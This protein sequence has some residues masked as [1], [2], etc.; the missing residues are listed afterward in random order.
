MRW[1]PL[2]AG[3][4][5][6]RNGV[7]SSPSIVPGNGQD[8]QFEVA[9][10][11]PASPDRARIH[12]VHHVRWSGRSPCQGRYLYQGSRV[13]ALQRYP[14]RQQI[15]PRLPGTVAGRVREPGPDLR[16][17]HRDNA[18]RCV[19]GSDQDRLRCLET[20][21]QPSMRPVVGLHPF[22]PDRR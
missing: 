21:R 12:T 9:V 2:L 20:L 16:R 5:S 19:D 13:P 18:S 8:S 14:G 1:N 4:R 22:H 10:P 6:P 17:T 11:P 15:V 3:R 7:A